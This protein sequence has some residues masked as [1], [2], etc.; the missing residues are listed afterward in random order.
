MMSTNAITSAQT[1]AAPAEP[2]LHVQPRGPRAD[3]PADVLNPRNPWSHKAAYETQAK[4]LA[5]MVRENFTKFEKFVPES[6]AKA[7]PSRE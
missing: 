3:V 4:N 1:P 2:P 6:V 7:G 5:S